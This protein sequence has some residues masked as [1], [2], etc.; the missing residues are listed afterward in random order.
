MNNKIA[1]VGDLHIGSQE[2]NATFVKY[3]FDSLCYF[4]DIFKTNGIKR[5]IF[6]GDI[7]NNRK[8]ITPI[9]MS[10]IKRLLKELKSRDLEPIFIAGNHD[11]FYKNTSELNNVELLLDRYEIV[12]NSAKEYFRNIVAIPWINKDNYEN[13]AESLDNSSADYLFAHA[14]FAGFDMIRGFKCQKSQ[15]KSNLITKFKKIYSGHFH[16]ISEHGNICYVGTPYELNWSDSNEIKRVIILDTLTGKETQ[17]NNPYKYFIKY[18]ISHEDDTKHNVE[19]LNDKNV[20]LY[21]NTAR[22]VEIEKFINR[23]T[24]KCYNVNIIDNNSLLKNMSIEIEESKK[25]TLIDIWN[26]YVKESKM[27]D[28]DSIM[29][30]KIFNE[31]YKDCIKI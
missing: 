20:K 26:E 18:Y 30:T 3:Q 6:L 27:N 28:K 15:I 10:L 7:F 17:H 5:V 1:I 8:H 24:E 12:T 14:E 29:L 11:I 9:T 21:L 4:L 25:N 23:L 22:T 13:I 19:Y 31:T 2:Q 16:C